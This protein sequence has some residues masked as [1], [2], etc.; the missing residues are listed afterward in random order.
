MLFDSQDWHKCN[1]SPLLQVLERDLVMMMDLMILS[2]L[3]KE[4]TLVIRMD[5]LKLS[6]NLLVVLMVPQSKDN[7]SMLKDLDY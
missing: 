7:D 4:C 1:H 5:N 2:V 3:G 6:A